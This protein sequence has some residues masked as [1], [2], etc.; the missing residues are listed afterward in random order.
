ML[1]WILAGSG[2]IGAV[3]AAH[4]AFTRAAAPWRKQIRAAAEAT[5][6][7]ASLI[8]A[9]AWQETNFDPSKVGKLGERGIG[10]FLPGAA[11]DVG[12][13]YQ[14]LINSVD[15]QFLGIGRY[16]KQNLDRFNGD[17]LTAVRAYN[18]GPGNAKDSPKA[19][20][21][22]ATAVVSNAAVDRLYTAVATFTGEYV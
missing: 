19:G 3:L 4:A 7:S 9:I 21:S 14:A 15:L 11:Q 8:A 5:G 2:V 17:L 12:I 13:D 20:L 22:Y 18:A 16:L 1:P 10:Q 6:V